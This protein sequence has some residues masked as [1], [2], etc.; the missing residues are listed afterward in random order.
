MNYEMF[1]GI[2]ALIL[3]LGIAWG[4]YQSKHRNRANDKITEEAVRQEYE[5]PSRYNDEIR[6]K[7]E[8]KVKPN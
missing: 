7:L 2:G 6:P 5:H 4:V 3:G 8:Q 1:Y